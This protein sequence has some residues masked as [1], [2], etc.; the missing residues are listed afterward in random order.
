MAELIKCEYIH[1][2]EYRGF[3]NQLAR[4]GISLSQGFWWVERVNGSVGV[5]YHLFQ[6][7]MYMGHVRREDLGNGDV[8]EALWKL[9]KYLEG[10]MK[11]P[12]WSILVFPNNWS[13]TSWYSKSFEFVV[14][15]GVRAKR[16]WSNFRKQELLM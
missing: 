14:M 16:E 9:M 15:S 1:S 12:D 10:Y 4:E 13:G 2:P 5:A 6:N 11:T 7:D 3:V 8:N